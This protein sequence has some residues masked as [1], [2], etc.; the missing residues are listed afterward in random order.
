M[1]CNWITCLR[2]N[3]IQCSNILSSAGDHITVRLFRD[4]CAYVSVWCTRA[5]CSRQIPTLSFL[6]LTHPFALFLTLLWQCPSACVCVLFANVVLLFFILLTSFDFVILLFKAL[7]MFL[8]NSANSARIQQ[9]HTHT[10][11]VYKVHN[12]YKHAYSINS[13]VKIKSQ[14]RENKKKRRIMNKKRLITKIINIRCAHF[15]R[16]LWLPGSH[17]SIQ[18]TLDTLRHW[19]THTN[20]KK[21]P[22]FYGI[23]HGKARSESNRYN[24][25][26]TKTTRKKNE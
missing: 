8:M 13:R 4:V 24:G 18:S 25:N 5:M 3:S 20:M 1:C 9:T 26:K 17:N 10:R 7:T 6:A 19:H 16:V 2:L 14:E 22:A 12:Y 23:Q 21:A 15:G 11:N